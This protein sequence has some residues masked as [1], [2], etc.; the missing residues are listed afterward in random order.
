MKK[1][2]IT[3]IQHPDYSFF[4]RIRALKDI[5]RYGVKAGDL[6]GYVESEWNLSQEGDCWV[7]GNA[8]VYE[9]ARVCGNAWV[10]GNARV[11]EDAQV[12]GNAWVGG[13]A[14]VHEDAQVNG[15][16]QVGGYAWVFYNLTA[17]MKVETG[18]WKKSMT[19]KEWNDMSWNEI[20]SKINVKEWIC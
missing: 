12:N 1:Y 8:W 13:Y 2:E 17:N 10:G 15:N 16:A 18:I 3:D 9:N 20:K 4:H 6:G 11:H 14:R 19:E 7:G 5:P